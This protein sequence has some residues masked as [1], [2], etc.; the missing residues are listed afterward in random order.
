MPVYSVHCVMGWRLFSWSMMK[1][2]TISIM[3][4]STLVAGA[5]ILQ[6]SRM[7][8]RPSKYSYVHSRR[9]M[10]IRGSQVS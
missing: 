8:G 4:D 1:R 3:Q 2:G 10:E 7:I 5:V 6:R 9:E